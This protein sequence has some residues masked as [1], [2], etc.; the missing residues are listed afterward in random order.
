VC[1]YW[2]GSSCAPPSP[3]RPLLSPAET[4]DSTLLSSPETQRHSQGNHLCLGWSSSKRMMWKDEGM[5]GCGLHRLSLQSI[6]H[7]SSSAACC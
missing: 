3:R 5:W 7:D 4:G 2:A 1:L 6:G